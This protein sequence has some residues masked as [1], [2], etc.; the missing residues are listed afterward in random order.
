M[1]DAVKEPG[2]VHIDHCVA[3]LLDIS[4][5]GQNGIV[6]SA[7][8]AKAVTV[9]AEGGIDQRLLHLQQCL[10]NQTVGHGG[11]A[12]FPLT[13]VRFRDAYPTDGLW[14]IGTLQKLLANAEPNP[15]QVFGCLAYVQ[16]V[17]TRRS[18]VSL[19][20]L[21]C[22]L[23][24]FSCERLLQQASPCALRFSSRESCFIADHVRQGFTLPLRDPPRWHLI[25]DKPH[26]QDV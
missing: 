22:P 3:T 19:Y 10:L 15:S 7:A 18:L 13:S 12:Q 17:D 14:P 20:A 16:T 8:R 6:G 24:I 9:L 2:Q 5:G 21:P 4:L 23:H 1:V 25:P 11:D 26:R